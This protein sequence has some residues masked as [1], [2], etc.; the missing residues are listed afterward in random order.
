MVDA[1]AD[2]PAAETGY[3]N[4]DCRIALGR[5]EGIPLALYRDLLVHEVT[6]AVLA[7]YRP[8]WSDRWAMLDQFSLHEALADLMALLSVFSSEEV[9]QR[10]I[11]VAMRRDDGPAADAAGRLDAALLR[12]GLFGLADDLFGRGRGLRSPLAAAPPAGWRTSLEPHARAAGIVHAVMETVL[13]LWNDRLDVPG[14]HSNAYLVA[15]AGAEVGLHL[16]GMLIRGLAYMVPVDAG[17]EDLLRGILAG[18]Q[19]VVPDDPR[20]YRRT[21]AACFAE[22]GVPAGDDAT[23][24]GTADLARLEYAFGNGMLD[25]GPEEMVRFVWNN[26]ALT[27]ALALDPSR[28]LAI[29]GVRTS[30][31]ISPSGFAVTETGASLVQ[32]FVADA[33]E[34]RALGVATESPVAFRGGALLRFDDGGRLVFASIKPVLDIDRQQARLDQLRR[35]RPTGGGD[36]GSA[37]FRDRML[38]LHARRW[39]GAQR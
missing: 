28:G 33:P 27:S 23:W 14:G 18:D 35:E 26:S 11:E 7:G 32:E 9:V 34:A 10:L 16:R 5:Q 37:G 15:S 4:A 38:A 3:R 30:T 17:P 24:M 1:D 29:D 6:H 31:R 20:G 36:P 19:T 12:S 22:V 13:R 25:A 39:A 21:L 2:I 8:R